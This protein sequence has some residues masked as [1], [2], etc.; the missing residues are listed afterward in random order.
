VAELAQGRRA[1]GGAAW[2]FATP[3]TYEHRLADY[4]P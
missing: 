4:L 2:T 3:F 1:Q